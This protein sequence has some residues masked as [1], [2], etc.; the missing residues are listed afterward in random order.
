MKSRPRHRVVLPAGWLAAFTAVSALLSGCVVAEQ[1]PPRREVIVEQAPAPPPPV[2]VAAPPP[3]YET[4]VVENGAPAEEIIVR[5]APPPLRVDVMLARPSPRHVWIAGYWHWQGNGYGWVRGHWVL[6]PRE[7]AVWVAP[8]FE[9]RAGGSVFITGF[10]RRG[11]V[12][13]AATVRTPPVAPGSHVLVIHEPP[14]PLRHEEILVARPSPH[15]VWIA[16]YWRHD[17][18]V[19]IWTAGHWERPP[20]EGLVWFAPRWELRGGGWVFIPG[21]WDRR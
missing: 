5:E 15:H 3:P 4:V 1:R 17:G 6:P 7:G 16:G 11:D 8:H 14:P 21:R 12:A 13:V 19:Y 10:W 2:E 18:H 9:A 20:R